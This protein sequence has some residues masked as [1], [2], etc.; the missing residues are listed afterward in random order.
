MFSNCFLKVPWLDFVCK[1]V[2]QLSVLLA[3]TTILLRLLLG[4]YTAKTYS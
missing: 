4:T 2:V 3:T 1:E